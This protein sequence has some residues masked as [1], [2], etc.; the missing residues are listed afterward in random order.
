MK[1]HHHVCPW[2]LAYSFDNPLRRFFHNPEKLFATYV[3]KGMRVADVGC[4]MGYFSVGLARMVGETG[5]VYSVDV[6]QKMLD[7]LAKRAAAQKLDH[8]ISPGL[9]E[10]AQLNLPMDLDFV[11][12]SWMVHETREKDA[13]FSQVSE[14]LKVGGFFYVT[15]P[16]M[17]VS[18]RAFEEEFAVVANLPLKITARP[19]VA[20]SRAAVFVK[21]DEPGI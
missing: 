19:K 8:L 11:L 20:F 1:E 18:E 3:H 5:Q 16:R 17:H 10:S 7:V 21:A 12:A 6:Q 14:A 9:A 4:G 2:W 15:E 13:F